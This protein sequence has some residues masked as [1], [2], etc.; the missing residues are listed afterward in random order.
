MESHYLASRKTNH[1]CSIPCDLLALFGTLFGWYTMIK[2]KELM[3]S[4]T[5]DSLISKAETYAE[6]HTY[7]DAALSDLSRT[8]IALLPKPLRKEYYHQINTTGI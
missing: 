7:P 4:P 8:L 6:S 2:Y 5:T 3:K 1:C